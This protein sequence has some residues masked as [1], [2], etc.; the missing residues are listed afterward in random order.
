MGSKIIFE[1][2]CFQ[3]FDRSVYLRPAYTNHPF[4]QYR[5]SVLNIAFCA[6]VFGFCQLCLKCR[7]LRLCVLF[8]FIPLL[9]RRAFFRRCFPI[10]NDDG[11]YT[12]IFQNGK[13]EIEA[14]HIPAIHQKLVEINT[15]INGNT[16]ILK[17]GERV[18]F[19]RM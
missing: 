11:L 1:P 6:F 7:I 2:E 15:D 18:P 17:I 19:N 13:E 16:F 10:E 4:F 9:Y 3:Q 8:V 5:H 14:F 12:I